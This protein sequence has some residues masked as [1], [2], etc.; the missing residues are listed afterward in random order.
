METS[1]NALLQHSS[2]MSRSDEETKEMMYSGRRER[3]EGKGMIYAETFKR[4]IIEKIS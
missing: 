3:A 2:Q 4:I 1:I